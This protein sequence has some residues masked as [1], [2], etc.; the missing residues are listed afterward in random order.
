MWEAV[1]QQ[2]KVDGQETV[3]QH[4]QVDGCEIV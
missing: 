3:E 1:Q 4:T 2:T